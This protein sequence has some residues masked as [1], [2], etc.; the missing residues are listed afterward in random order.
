MNKQEF[1]FLEGKGIPY[2]HVYHLLCGT[3]KSNDHY[4]HDENLEGH[5][6][7]SSDKE[8]QEINEMES[9]LGNLQTEILDL[10]T[11]VDFCCIWRYD[12]PA[13][14]HLICK[15]IGGSGNTMSRCHYQVGTDKRDEL[16]E[17]ALALKKWLGKGGDEKAVSLKDSKTKE[18]IELRVFDMLGQKE[19]LKELLVERTLIGLISRHIDCSFFGSDSEG[20][21]V[22]MHPCHA[23][24]LP[25][26]GSSKM[27][28]LESEIVNRLGGRAYDFLCEVGGAEPPCHFKFI[29]RLEILIG[30]IGCLKWRGCLPPKDSKVTG[31]RQLTSKYLSLLLSYWKDAPLE[32]EWESDDSCQALKKEL[33]D[34][35]G[36]SQ[37]Y[38][39]WLVASLWKNIKNQTQYQAFTMK[40]WVEFVQIMRRQINSTYDGVY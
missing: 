35:L 3:K 1:N 33:F 16:T 21:S 28:K 20:K 36:E 9:Q 37:L 27:R 10:R 25:N 32:G 7:G 17:Y 39:R 19:E 13:R 5:S 31:R 24:D 23:L 38:K 14:V 18:D 12:Y 34:A 11:M 15:A 29:R 30:S 2:R 6:W 26:G 40:R 8:I 4:F 22:N